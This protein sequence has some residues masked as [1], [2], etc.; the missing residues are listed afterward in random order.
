MFTIYRFDHILLL[1]SFHSFHAVEDFHVSPENM[2]RK[3]VMNFNDES[4]Q[5]YYIL[6]YPACKSSWAP[7]PYGLRDGYT[8]CRDQDYYSNAFICSFTQLG[9]IISIYS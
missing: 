5:F 2:Y 3:A 9:L 1:I 6:T 4:M 8:Y 7:N